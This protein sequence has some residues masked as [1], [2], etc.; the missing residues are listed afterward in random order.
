MRTFLTTTA[1]VFVGLLLFV[2][3]APFLLIGVVAA[4]AAAGGDE[5]V[6]D[7]VVI[8][9]D[10]R[11]EFVDQPDGAF[12]VSDDRTIIDVVSGL[13]R[14]RRDARVRGLFI[15]A[16]QGGLSPA[17]AEELHDAVQRFR[18]S[19]RFVVAHS[20]GFESP[21]FSAY[22]ASSAADE[23]WL[24][25]TGS[26][27]SAGLTA[28]TPFVGGLL[29]RIGVS[30]EFERF[31]EYKNG[32]NTYT[33][34]S[35]TPEHR[36]ALQAVLQSL[37][38][39]SVRIAAASRERTPAELR[40]LVEAGPYTAEIALENRLVDALGHVEAAREHA[41]ERAGDGAA[42][43]EMGAYL[44]EET[45]EPPASDVIALVMG[46]GAVMTG[47]SGGGWSDDENL[48]SDTIADAIREAAEDD[49]VRAIVLRVDSPGGSPTASDQIYDAVRRA[50]EDGTP[51]VASFAGVAASG[52]Y[53]LA[54]G[55]NEIFA[56]ST[57]ITG[58]I[59]VYGGKFVLDDALNRIGVNLEPLAVGG[60]YALAFSPSTPFSQTQR[61]AF[62]AMM[63]ETYADFIQAV[64]TG[65][66]LDEDTVREV[67]RGRIW[68]G[69]QALERDLID[70]RGGVYEAL[71]RARELGGLQEGARYDIRRYPEPRTAFEE[72]ADL[73][74]MSVETAQTLGR[75]EAVMSSP[76][77]RALLEAENAR[78]P[79]VSVRANPPQFD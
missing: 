31:E 73:F 59:G 17:Q 3:I 2:I 19:G 65:R 33:Q 42:F 68:S 4:I 40:A 21:S 43:I 38:E 78:A 34:T 46:Q 28:H 41:L 20:Q 49:D 23:I 16:S 22:L 70:A 26:F 72:I 71:E 79:G 52:G 47:E 54:A 53:Y 14:A 30:P 63:A 66:G 74:G 56:P 8:T 18:D 51:V 27:A 77:M 12:G 5:P 67:A 48:H 6:G 58:S 55:A 29:E 25:A 62:R 13:E 44:D 76:E 75:I 1:G 10:L 57:S 24:Q 60:D 61:D 35:Y 69:A 15:R 9:L 39:E 36:R 7:N 64:A 11:G 32:P 45:Y 50:R 37:Y